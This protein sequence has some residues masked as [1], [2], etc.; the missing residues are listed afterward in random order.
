MFVFAV[1]GFPIEE[2]SRCFYEKYRHQV[3]CFDLALEPA[4][5]DAFNILKRW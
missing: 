3:K 4:L 1:S 2:K 5:M